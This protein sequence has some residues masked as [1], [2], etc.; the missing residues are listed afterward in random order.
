MYCATAMSPHAREIAP[1]A[2]RRRPTRHQAGAHPGPDPHCQSHGQR[3]TRAL[4]IP[5]AVFVARARCHL[6]CV[7][8][9]R[10]RLEQCTVLTARRP[11]LPRSSVPPAVRPASAAR[12]TVAP[13]RRRR[14]HLILIR[15]HHLLPSPL[16][17]R[18]WAHPHRDPDVPSTCGS[19]SPPRTPRS[20]PPRAS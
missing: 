9:L 11:R 1:D 4:V 17:A 5:H 20:S 19:R 2:V 13:H 15:Q 10:D 3:V 18:R 16:D 6:R 7:P 8:G 12:A 14:L